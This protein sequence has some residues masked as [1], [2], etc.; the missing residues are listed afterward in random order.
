MSFNNVFKNKNVLVTGHTGFKGSWLTLWLK[1]LGANICGI[2]LD[3]KTQPSNFESIN[4]SNQIKDLRIDILN[5]KKL[6]SAII[7]FK[8]DFIFHLAAQAIVKESYEDPVNTW[9]TNLIGT[10]N[11]MEALRK[12]QKKCTAILVTSDKCYKNKE[13]LWGYRENDELGGID[14]YSASKAATEIAINSYIKSFFKA[15][16]LVSICSV[17]AGNVIGGGDWSANRLLPDC[18]KSWSKNET[19]ILRSPQSTRPWQH[20]L[21]PLSGYLSLATELNT[22]N[23]LNGESFNFGPIDTEQHTVINVVNEISQYWDKVKWEVDEKSEIYESQLLRL[24]CDKA[25]NYIKWTPVMNF[26]E[27]IKFTSEWYQKFYNDPKNMRE[28]S[29]NQIKEFTHLA[30]LKNLSWSKC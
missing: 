24:N 22:N 7:N 1:H 28:F 25:F 20:V 18:I 19:V 15:S 17:R 13:W 14:P 21:E 4:L 3:P 27:T 26:K 29:I 10:I 8:P 11:I 2:A 12:S 16:N 5:L 6:E 9:K 30:N 23:Q